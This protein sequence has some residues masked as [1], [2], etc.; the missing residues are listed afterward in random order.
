MSREVNDTENVILSSCQTDL[1]NREK[2][3]QIG[4]HRNQKILHAKKLRANLKD[5]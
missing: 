3:K 1:I 2:C 5:K 4:L